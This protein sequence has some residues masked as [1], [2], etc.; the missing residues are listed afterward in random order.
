M[1]FVNGAQLLNINFLLVLFGVA[2]VSGEIVIV[3]LTSRY[4]SL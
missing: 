1:Q 3:P 2:V 4:A